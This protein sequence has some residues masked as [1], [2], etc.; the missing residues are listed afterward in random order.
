MVKQHEVEHVKKP[1]NDVNENEDDD[2]LEINEKSL[3]VQNN[4]SS[5][6]KYTIERIEEDEAYE[7]ICINV[8][9]NLCPVFIYCSC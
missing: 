5:K 9:T 7:D 4:K 2:S 8:S 6:R 3:E 1:K